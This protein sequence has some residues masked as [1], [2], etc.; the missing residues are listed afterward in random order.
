[1]KGSLHKAFGSSL[2]PSLKSKPPGL[3]KE[4]LGVPKNFSKVQEIKIDFYD[5]FIYIPKSLSMSRNFFA[6]HI[7]VLKI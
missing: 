5:C 4:S 1:M 6:C 2:Y 3:F 7:G